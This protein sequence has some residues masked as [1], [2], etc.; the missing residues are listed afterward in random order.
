MA[1]YSLQS[2]PQL[3]RARMFGRCAKCVS[4]FVLI[5]APFFL[6][7]ACAPPQRREDLHYFLERQQC[8]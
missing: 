8:F 6:L 7:E 3:G 4:I 2:A 1:L 5:R